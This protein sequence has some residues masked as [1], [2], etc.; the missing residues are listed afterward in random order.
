L[1]DY[2]S[3]AE[4]APDYDSSRDAL[5][6][7]IVLGALHSVGRPL[8]S[9]SVIDAA[10][11]TG[12]YAAALY[13]RVGELSC[14]DL[15][16]A[17][18]EQA[19]AKLGE[20]PG[21]TFHIGD[22][23]VLP[24]PDTSA[25]AVLFNQAA[26]HLEAP[27]D[28]E[29]FRT[30]AGFMERAFAVLRPGGVFCMNTSSRRQVTDGYWWADLI[31]EAVAE[32]QRRYPPISVLRD[33]LGRAGFRDIRRVVPLDE[34]LQARG[35][36]EADGPLRSE[37]RAGDSTWSLVSSAELGRAQARVRALLE[38]GEMA[39]YLEHREALRLAQGQT[40]FVIANKRVTDE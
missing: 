22:A 40:T 25:D 21:V 38:S 8:G 15:A 29:A 3:Y 35:Y 12:N 10:C 33:L 1:S 20:G 39:G 30:L 27:E 5:G 26:Q 36:L 31:P 16:P 24:F 11:G 37:W 28:T 34:V 18:L 14:L 6:V 4:T 32:I 13:G 19:R 23:A 2:E 7:D 17:M 9:L